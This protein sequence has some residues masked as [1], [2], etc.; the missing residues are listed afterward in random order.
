MEVEGK[1][2]MIEEDVGHGGDTIESSEECKPYKAI[3]EKPF[4]D[5]TRHIKPLYVRAHLNVRSV[6]MQG[7]DR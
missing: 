7:T 1:H 3:L 4:V 2:P 5:M 6:S